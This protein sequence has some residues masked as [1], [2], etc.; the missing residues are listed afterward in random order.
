MSLCIYCAVLCCAV[1]CCAIMQPGLGNVSV[2]RMGL[3]RE[4]LFYVTRIYKK[5]CDPDTPG[6]GSICFL[7][8][9]KKQYAVK[10]F[11]FSK[12]RSDAMR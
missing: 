5:S 6:N 1:L 12:V 2:T 4:G 7:I 8:R 3:E 9:K 10:V 11:N